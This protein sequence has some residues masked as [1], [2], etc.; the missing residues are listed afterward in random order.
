MRALSKCCAVHCNGCG[1]TNSFV[2]Q[3]LDLH[4]TARAHMYS[5]LLKIKPIAESPDLPQSISRGLS[6]PD[7][8][9]EE[10][11]ALHNV[12]SGL[13]NREPVKQ[14]VDRAVASACESLK[15]KLPNKAKRSRKS[16][17]AETEEQPADPSPEAPGSRRETS[18]QDVRASV[19]E[20]DDAD[21]ESE[22]E[23][24]SDNDDPVHQ[25]EELDSEDEAAEEKSISKYDHLLGGDS[26]SDSDDED[27]NNERFER[28]KGTEK[29]NLD[30]ISISGSDAEPQ[31]G[32]DSEEEPDD[33][34]QNPSLSPSPHPVKKKKKDKAA[35]RTARPRDSTFLPSLMGGYISGSESA[36]D[37]DVAPAKKRRGQRA[38]QAIWEKKYGTT[39]KHLSKPQKKGRDSGWDSK[40]GAV[41][42]GDSRTPWK[43]GIRDP[44]DKVKKQVPTKKD[45]EGVLHPSWAARK[46]AKE[47]EK[48]VAFSG[49]KIVF[50]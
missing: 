2:P 31:L 17:Q 47:A 27:F 40:R 28:F 49:A 15:V 21:E 12:T 11:A 29:V 6:K 26:D 3:S 16:K 20:D 45:D 5:S 42:G 36:S 43:Q 37:I 32:S 35:S 48:T 34:V 46:K 4:Q 14:A 25:P 18:S 41:E 38:R 24:F 19:E 1:K 7:L 13:Y 9:P 30:D 44:L 50:D 33:D 22:F 10:Q 23:G 39:A 8:S